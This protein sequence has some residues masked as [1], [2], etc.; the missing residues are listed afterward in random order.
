MEEGQEASSNTSVKPASA[1]PQKAHQRGRFWPMRLAADPASVALRAGL[2]PANRGRRTAA[3]AGLRRRCG[4]RRSQGLRQD[5]DRHATG[6]IT[7]AARH[8]PGRACWMS[9]RWPQSCGLRCGGPLML[10]ITGTVRADRLRRAGGGCRPTH[11]PGTFCDTGDEGIE[12]GG[13]RRVQRGRITA[14]YV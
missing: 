14:R 8:R 2:H 11:R 1:S 9:G 13:N 4:D 6:R 3:A 5:D 12:P 7:G 10:R